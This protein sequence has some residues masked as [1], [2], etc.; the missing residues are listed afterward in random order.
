MRV[1]STIGF[2]LLSIAVACGPLAA[3]ESIATL[4][5]KSQESRPRKWSGEWKL[6]M[7][8]TSL[9]EGK[10]E[11]AAAFAWFGANFK[12]NFA[13]WLKAEISP[14]ISFYSSRLQ[15]RY[16]DDS[17]QNRLWMMG[18]HLS[19]I[20][21]EY[22]EFR[23]GALN[24]GFLGSSML[25]SSLRSFPGL[26]ETA[27]F[28]TA[29]VEG[30]LIL[31]QAVPTSH[32]LNTERERMEKLPSFNTESVS[33]KGK[34]FGLVEWKATGGHF[35][36]ANLPSKVAWESRIDGAL[37]SGLEVTDSRF[38]YDHEGWFGTA[39]ACWCTT[40]AVDF[41]LEFQRIHNTK[42]DSFAADAQSFGLG[43]KFKIGDVE[44]DLRYRSFFIESD[45]TVALYNKSRFGHTNRIGDQIEASANFKDQGFSIF[46]QAV[47]ARPI[48]PSEAQR[49]LSI[50]FVGVETEYAPF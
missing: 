31:Q 5:T 14:N 20:P 47:R 2:L 34:H 43:P 15:E 22:L 46:A 41:T 8:G 38:T 24:Q 1:G 30:K 39:E 48:N 19:V 33:L 35:K 40:A 37:G 29:E 4:E 27:K 9:S 36:W 13:K 32:T 44:V 3:S 16:D 12:Y 7:G 50:Y 6:T 26:Q 10:D 49:D 18:A 28:K 17:Y 25:V 45:A 11:G 42:A 23:A 21:V